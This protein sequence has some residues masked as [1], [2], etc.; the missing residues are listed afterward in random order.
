MKSVAR[1]SGMTPPPPQPVVSSEDVTPIAWRPLYASDQPFDPQQIGRYAL[2]PLTEDPS[3]PYTQ[4]QRKSGFPLGNMRRNFAGGMP[5]WQQTAQVQKYPGTQ[6][7]GKTWSPRQLD[8]FSI[9]N[10][11][12]AVVASSVAQSGQAVLPFMQA[13]NANAPAANPNG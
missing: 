11:R 3:A 12:Q 4:L 9:W 2:P 5:Y 7:A 13:V 1:L 6:R 8:R 10:Q